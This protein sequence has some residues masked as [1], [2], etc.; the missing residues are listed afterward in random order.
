[1]NRKIRRQSP[2]KGGRI[3]LPSCVLNEIEEQVEYLARKYSVSRSWVVSSLL[4]DAFGIGKKI[5]KR[6]YELEEQTIRRVK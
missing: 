4:A 2:V 3:P 5:Q 6:Y 1:M